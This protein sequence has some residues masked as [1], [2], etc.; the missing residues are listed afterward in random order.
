M[1]L[2]IFL[3]PPG[4][5]REAFFDT[6]P[7]DV[8]EFLRSGFSE[9]AI[10]PEASLASIADQVSRWIDPVEPEPAIDILAREF[11]VGRRNMSAMISALTLLVSARFAGPNP[12]DLD[13]FVT[14]AI[15]ANIL[16][17]DDAEVVLAFGRTQLAAQSSALSDALV[18]ANWSTHI[19]PSFEHL[20]TVVD[21]RVVAINDERV[22]TAP[23]VIAT[24]RTDVSDQEL[25][26]QMTPRDVGQLVEQLQKLT[27]QLARSKG[28]TIQLASP[29]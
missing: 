9:L 25:L 8:R 28:A 20:A 2:G 19:V 4:I 14:K 24:L 29:E 21:L 11:K 12:M 13:A 26:F 18:R 1:S 23:V 3:L 5:Q 6:M 7:E 17:Q 15:D 16:K 22:V 27:E 10:L